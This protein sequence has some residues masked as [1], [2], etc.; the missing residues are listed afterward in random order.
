MKVQQAA[1]DIVAPIGRAG[2]GPTGWAYRITNASA[3]TADVY[4]YAEISE[5]G[6]TADAFQ[7]ALSEVQ[8]RAINLHVHSPGGN[9]FD[10]IAIYNALRTHPAHVTAYVEGLAASAASI[11]VQAADRRVMMRH[12]QM[13]IHN[14]RVDAFGVTAQDMDELKA[15]L[16]RQDSVLAGIYL[17]RTKGGK[18][19][20]GKILEA[21]AAETWFTDEEAVKFRLADAVETPKFQGAP[22]DEDPDEED[23][24][25]VP[26]DDDEDAAAEADDEDA[27]NAQQA[28]DT[29]RQ[30]LAE[31]EE[32]GYDLEDLIG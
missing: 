19:K 25:P 18:A 7:A 30:A 29:L 13:M 4:L 10:G 5:M 16:E 22:D 26:G 15:I 1:N 21:M 2:T 17:E 28:L 32:D 14:T 23:A 3:P 12:S 6:V 24:P 27:A 8:S 11:I 31:I 20:L 9:V